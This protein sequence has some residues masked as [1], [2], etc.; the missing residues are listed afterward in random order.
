MKEQKIGAVKIM[1]G[2]NKYPAK[3]PNIAPKFG[4]DTQI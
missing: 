1:H 4:F 3:A 2:L